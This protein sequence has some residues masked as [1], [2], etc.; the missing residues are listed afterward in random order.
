M[1]TCGK[2]N[3]NNMNQ[4]ILV[5]INGSIRKEL[6]RGNCLDCEKEPVLAEKSSRWE[7]EVNEECGLGCLNLFPNFHFCP[8]VS[9]EEIKCE[10]QTLR[11]GGRKMLTHPSL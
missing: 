2:K 4:L 3:G 11:C 9:T 6:Q 5:W 1:V 7:R 8:S 10:K